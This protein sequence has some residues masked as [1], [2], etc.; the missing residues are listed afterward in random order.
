M[1]CFFR[2]QS[3]YFSGNGKDGSEPSA[4]KNWPARLECPYLMLADE[5]VW[6]RAYVSFQHD[7]PTTD[8]AQNV[9]RSRTDLTSLLILLLL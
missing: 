7:I 2:A 8:Q 9:Y 1:S 3:K 6:N 4:R 5:T